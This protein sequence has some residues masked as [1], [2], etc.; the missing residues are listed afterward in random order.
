MII[1]KLVALVTFSFVIFSS[2]FA[3]ASSALDEKTQGLHG[4]LSMQIVSDHDKYTHGFSWYSN[5]WGMLDKPIR[6]F[7]VGLPSTWI[8]PDDDTISLANPLC[9]KGTYA[10]DHWPERGPLWKDVFQTIEGGAGQWGDTQFPSKTPKFRINGTPDCYTS[11]VSFSARQ[12]SHSDRRLASSAM[13]IVQLSNHLLIPPDGLTFRSTIAKKN[14]ALLGT[15]W[16]DLP[17]FQA[18]KDGITG[19]QAWT[20]FLNTNNFKGPVAFWLPQAWSKISKNYPE[21][22]H[23]GLDSFPA[24]MKS[25]AIEIAQTPS[26]VV[27]SSG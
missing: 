5:V 19:D 9:P 10:R 12:F 16:M 25:G 23:L 26:Y 18:E 17:L 21:D 1:K 7:Q 3:T 6:Y 22:L 8:T 14:V 2:V 20:L 4:Y 13:A 24:T 11:Q 27:S 15:A